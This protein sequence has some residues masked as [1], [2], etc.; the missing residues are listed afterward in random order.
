MT[1][2][3]PVTTVAIGMELKGKPAKPVA[4]AP[5]KST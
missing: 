3:I 4:T 5:V 2:L 1:S